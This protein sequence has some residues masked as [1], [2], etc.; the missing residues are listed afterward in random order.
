MTEWKK[1]KKKSMAFVVPVIW[2]ETTSHLKDWYFCLMKL[3]MFSRSRKN[4]VEY[5]NILS[6]VKPM[7]HRAILLLYRQLT[8]RNFLFS[9][10][11]K[12][13]IVWKACQHLIHTVAKS[14]T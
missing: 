13:K 14:H 3:L 10:K 8:G 12:K 4:T 9:M 1:G 7:P 6:A 5:P 2:R 11:K